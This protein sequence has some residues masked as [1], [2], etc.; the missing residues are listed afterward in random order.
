MFIGL[1]I[2]IWPKLD[3]KKVTK[4]MFDERRAQC[5]FVCLNLISSLRVWGWLH[6]ASSLIYYKF[7]D[8]YFIRLQGV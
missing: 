1:N 3:S 4:I 2:L 5:W 6:V 8:S 7:C